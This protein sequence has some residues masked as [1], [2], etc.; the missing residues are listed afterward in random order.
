MLDV[1]SHGR[2]ELGVGKGITPYEHLQFGHSPEEAS[3]RSADI[4]RM[5]LEGWQTGIISSDES[6]F[7]DFVELQLPFKPIQHPYPPLW[8]AGNA[9]TAGRGGHNFIFPTV[10]PTE[11]RAR[12]DELRAESREQ[13]GHQNPHVPEPR[14]AQ[15]QGVVIADTDAEAEA[16]A[17]RAWGTTRRSF[18]ELTATFPRTC[19]P[20]CRDWDNP[21]AKKMMSLDPLE[22]GLVIAG[23]VERVRDYYVEQ[24]RLGV[25]N[26]FVLMLP[27]ADLTREEA[28]NTL[29][30][31][32]TEVIPGCPI[33]RACRRLRLTRSWPSRCQHQQYKGFTTSPTASAARRRT[34]TS[35][36][37][38]SVCGC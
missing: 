34:S 4:L 28:W 29:D 10:I 35:T 6:P 14:I 8:T 12:Y 2:L 20:R 18:S 25:A 37:R 24:A 32:I 16:I 1:L 9:E 38:C 13:P 7:Y 22:S 33:G 19:R 11:M 23:S 36:R 5:L 15:S 17:R 21:L 27:F 3:A 31:F 26:Y 30:S